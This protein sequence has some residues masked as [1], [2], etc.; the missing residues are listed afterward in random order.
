M[1]RIEK[2]SFM[3]LTVSLIDYVHRHYNSDYVAV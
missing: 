3:G 2:S 1:V